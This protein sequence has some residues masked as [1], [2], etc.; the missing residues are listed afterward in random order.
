MNKDKQESVRMIFRVDKHLRKQYKQYCLKN[1]IVMSERIRT[2][3]E[4][5]LKGKI[6]T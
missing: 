4:L 6:I 5:D 1:D 3:I 2:L